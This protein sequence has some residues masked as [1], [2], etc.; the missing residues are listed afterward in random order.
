VI[1]ASTAGRA[2]NFWSASHKPA[3]L[4][5]RFTG[6]LASSKLLAG[7]S[8]DDWAG[9][10]TY[11]LDQRYPKPDGSTSAIYRLDSASLTSATATAAG[12]PGSCR[13]EARGTGGTIA[14]GD[15]ELRVDK[16]GNATYAVLYDV[17][18]PTTFSPV[19]CP[20]GGGPPPLDIPIVGFLNSHL[21]GWPA[22]D[23]FRPVG[24]GWRLEA[25]DVS[26]VAAAPGESVSAS[27]DLEPAT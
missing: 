2:S 18:I 19:D 7:V 20:P 3:D 25:H 1:G 22:H 9:T 6:T 26:D 5:A 8:S 23:A 14:D 10:A 13:L 15:I 11:V 4:P 16:D 21:A 17:E 24:A 27:W 12:V